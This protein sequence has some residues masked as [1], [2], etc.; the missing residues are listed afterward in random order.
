M[1]IYKDPNMMRQLMLDNY[2]FPHNKGLS[3][4][5]KYQEVHMHSASCIDDIRVQ[6]YVE[7]ETI[8]DIKFDGIGCVI[9]ISSTSIMSDLLKGK[10]KAEAKKIIDNYMLMMREKDCD[11]ALLEEAVIFHNV[12]KQANR[13]KCATISWN[14]VKEILGYQDEEE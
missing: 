6:I 4:D 8:K 2:Q 12:P 13:I 7:E 9:S 5:P 11:E 3:T 10:T 14:A 1:S